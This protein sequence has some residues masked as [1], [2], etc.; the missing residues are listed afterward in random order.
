MDNQTTQTKPEEKKEEGEFVGATTSM[1][2]IELTAII[3]RYAAEIEK[4]KNQLKEQNSMYRDAFE[5]DAEYHEQSLKIKELKKIQNSAK[6]RILKLPSMEAVT[7]KIE[8]IKSSIKD[9]QEMLS[10]YLEQYQKVSGT[11]IIE[12]EDGK[13]R[14]IIPVFKLVNRKT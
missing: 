9:G 2:I 8:E 11:N 5:G 3:N 7:A 4:Y 6:E 14:E 10:G 12:T 13:I 1:N